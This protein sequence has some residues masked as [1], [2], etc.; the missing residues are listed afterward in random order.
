MIKYRVFQSKAA[1]QNAARKIYG[2]AMQNRADEMLGFLHD[3]NNGKAKTQVKN[4]PP[5]Q[6][7]NSDRF[8]LYGRNAAS[9][10]LE[11]DYGHTKAWAIPVEIN[12]GRWVFQSPDDTGIPAEDDWW[13]EPDLQIININ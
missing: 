13:I 8:P 11:K 9:Q 2:D 7:E 4:L 3:W 10:A 1:A 12:D 5:G 6:L